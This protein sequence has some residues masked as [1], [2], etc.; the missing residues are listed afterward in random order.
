MMHFSNDQHRRTT[1]GSHGRS[2][3]VRTASV[4]TSAL[5]GCA[6]LVAACGSS[7]SSP[8][9]AAGN[10]GGAG[11]SATTITIK[12]FTF[13][14]ATLRVS[15]G[16]TVTVANNDSVAHTMTSTTKKFD[17]GDVAPGASATFKAPTTPGTYA[18]IC[19]IHQ[20]MH[21]TLVVT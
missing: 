1:V 5:V 20:F 12:N 21:G 7:P 11:A 8:S 18:Y 15:P 9:S 3:R 2:R 4:L 17:T 19:T 10:S 16:A 14:P 13:S 6:F